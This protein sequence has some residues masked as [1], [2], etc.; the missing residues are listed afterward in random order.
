MPLLLAPPNNLNGVMSTLPSNGDRTQK[1]GSGAWD[2][3]PDL[4]AYEA[5]ALPIKLARDGGR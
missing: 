5:G 4:T 3:N 2:L 1:G